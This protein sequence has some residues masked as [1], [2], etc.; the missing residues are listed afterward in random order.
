M[1]PIL[2]IALP[3]NSPIC[4]ILYISCLSSLLTQSFTLV[5][6]SLRRYSQKIRTI[7]LDGKTIKLQIWDTAGQERYR[8]ITTA[9]YRDAVGALIVYDI[10]KEESYNNVVRWVKD[11][12]NNTNNRDISIILG[13]ND[14]ASLS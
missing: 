7:E 14:S 3:P 9:Y 5:Q 8:A 2:D 11:V 10:T 1:E 4:H 6:L 12:R 13:S